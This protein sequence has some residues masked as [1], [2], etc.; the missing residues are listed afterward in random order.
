M[1]ILRKIGDAGECFAARYLQERGY[2]LLSKN[3][4]VHRRGEIDL[5]MEKDEFLVCVEIKTRRSTAV[6]FEAL[7][8]WRK[9]QRIV[10]AARCY[11]QRWQLTEK[12]VRFDV[13]F[14]DVSSGV[15]VITHV[16]NAFQ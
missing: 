2:R 11:V 5:V 10:F 9:Q 13:V 14:V 4:T 1:H 7:V 3:F 8:P 6:P 16:E 15:P 12:V